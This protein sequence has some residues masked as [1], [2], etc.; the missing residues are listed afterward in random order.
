[1]TCIDLKIP[2]IIIIS[3]SYWR[4]ANGHYADQS[5]SWQF[6]NTLLNTEKTILTNKIPIH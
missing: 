4:H 3:E 5:D 1:M 6:Q 2:S